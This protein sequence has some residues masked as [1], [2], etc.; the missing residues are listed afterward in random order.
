MFAPKVH[1]EGRNSVLR[2]KQRNLSQGFLN[3][4]GQNSLK[5]KAAASQQDADSPPKPDEPPRQGR[6]SVRSNIAL[7]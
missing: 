7:F 5:D 2:N 6:G 3:Q 4:V 1:G